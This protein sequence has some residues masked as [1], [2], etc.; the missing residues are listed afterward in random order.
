L[1][2]VEEIL[3]LEVIVNT[4]VI[5]SEVLEGNFVI[6]GFDELR[7]YVAHGAGFAFEVIV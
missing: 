1:Q 7:G 2:H 5:I 4:L 6:C 3:E